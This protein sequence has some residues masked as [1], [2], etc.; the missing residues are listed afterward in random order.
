[1]PPQKPFL[2]VDNVFDRIGLYPLATLNPSSSLVGREVNYLADYRRERTLWQLAASI[3]NWQVISDLGAG[4]TLAGVSGCWFDRGHNFWGHTINLGSSNDNFATN[5]DFTNRAAVPAQG[6]LGGDPTTGWC[7]TEEGAIYTIWTP[8]VNPARYFRFWSGDNFQAQ[9]TGVV[10]GARTQLLGFSNVVD[11]DAGERFERSEA[12]LIPGYSGD[13]RTYSARKV[14]LDLKLIGA[15]EYDSSIR[16]LRRLLFDRNQPA[17][18]CTNYGSYPERTWLYKFKG[19]QWSAPL[20]RTMRSTK[21][22]LYE[23]GPLIR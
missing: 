1:M 14:D 5:A 3:P 20:S 8:W 12:S 17:V 21:I 2:L 10:M 16:T 23:Y 18:V 7:V 19:G 11:E 4:N 6:T 9:C 22:S 13:D 15:A